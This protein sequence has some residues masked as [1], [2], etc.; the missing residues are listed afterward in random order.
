MLEEEYRT[1][2]NCATTYLKDWQKMN[3]NDL[4]N[5]Y[6]DNEQNEILKGAYFSALML[7]Y[8]GNIGK[9]YNLSKSSGFTIDECYSWLVEAIMYAL[10]MRKWRDKNNYLYTDPNGPDKVINRCIYSRRKYYYYLSNLDNRAANHNKD[11]LDNLLES[12]IKEDYN[13][14]LE[15]DESKETGFKL[16]TFYILNNLINRHKYIEAIVVYVILTKNCVNV[17]ENKEYV[18]N[19][20]AL[21]RRLLTTNYDSFLDTFNMENSTCVKYIKELKSL[22]R[23]KV[24]TLAKKIIDS[25]SASTEF[26]EILC[27]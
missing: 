8:W 12:N 15:V 1:F 6:I 25:L 11:S 22:G 13:R 17:N 26:K 20:N 27:Y 21:S 3:K 18:I 19:F 4:A 16:D 10:K 9:Y 5:G 14:I 24:K 23:G 2:Y 7:R